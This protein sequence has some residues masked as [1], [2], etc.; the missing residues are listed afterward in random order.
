MAQSSTK[1]VH[2]VSLGCPK[3]RVDT[4]VMM[5]RLA[6]AGITPTADPSTADVLLVNTCAFIASSKEESV[7]AI[8]EL[9]EHKARNS[10]AKLVVAGCLSQ[11]HAPQLREEMPEVDF[12][13]G[14]GEYQRLAELLQ[15]D[16][17]VAVTSAA[18]RGLRKGRPHYIADHLQPRYVAKDT[19]STYLKIAEGCSQGCS[20]CIIPKLRGVQRS[21]TVQDN[22]EEARRLVELGVV[23]IN[24][25]AQDL[26]HYGEDIDDPDALARL[27]EALGQVDGLRWVRLMYVYPDNFT[28]ALIDAVAETDNCLPYIDMPLQHASDRVLKRMNRLTSR[29]QIETL[30]NKLRQRVDDL[31]LRTTILV[32]HPGESEADFESLCEFVGEQRFDR[33]GCFM[34]SQEE[35]TLSARMP[36]QVQTV[37]KR[38]RH[39]RIMAMQQSIARQHM[40]DR[41][42][43]RIEVL[44]EG[45]SDETDLLLQGR[46]W[47]QAPEIDGLVY[48]ND[49]PADIGRGQIR[50]VQ[51]TD[52]VGDY[53]LLGH[54]VDGPRGQATAIAAR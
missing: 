22:V 24:L 3:N 31:V 17:A 23:E 29:H 21:R 42:G 30:L 18:A 32:G 15:L 12:F 27:V 10:D 33:L 38:H 6:Q 20:F 41:V 48:I 40:T 50:D 28:D 47:S 26:T 35:G 34:Y 19:Y 16:D 5:G 25:I 46:S 13:I 9:A 14:T 7:D 39:A 54:V 45:L 4:E 36:D 53:D 44:V 52:V 1:T 43:Q 51:I 8:L 2:V 37:V 11:R 49:A